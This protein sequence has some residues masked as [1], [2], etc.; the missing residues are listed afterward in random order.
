MYHASESSDFYREFHAAQTLEDNARQ[1][2]IDAES[3]FSRHARDTMETI[4]GLFQ[5]LPIF[6]LAYYVAVKIAC[7]S[8]YSTLSLEDE[9]LCHYFGNWLVLFLRYS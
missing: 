3:Y 8:N 9:M 7:F 4:S 6:Y 1:E 5:F 2:E